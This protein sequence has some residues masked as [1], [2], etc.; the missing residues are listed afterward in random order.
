MSLEYKKRLKEQYG[1]KAVVA[2]E[3]LTF[4]NT[5]LG[6]GVLSDATVADAGGITD[7]RAKQ[8]TKLDGVSCDLTAVLASGESLTLNILVAAV[9]VGTIT[10]VAGERSGVV[11]FETKNAADVNLSAGQV[12]QLTVDKSATA[13]NP[14]ITARAN[15]RVIEA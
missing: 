3:T 12:L 7:Y 8:T 11:T 6:T 4:A 5:A 2:Y 9:S 15:L 1:R 13:G 14:G 10:L